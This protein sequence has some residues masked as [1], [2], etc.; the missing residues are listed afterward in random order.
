MH[1]VVS[2]TLGGLS[3]Q[4]YVR[5]FAFGAA[6]AAVIISMGARGP[7]PLPLGMI[8]LLVVNAVL[9]PYSRFVYERAVGFVVG[10]NV[11][12]VPAFISLFCKVMTMALCFAGAMFL[13]PVGLA[14]LYFNH[15]AP[16]PPRNS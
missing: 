12:I 1:S 13:A 14:Y 5:Q 10:D 16:D 4:Y 6:M 8:V 15:R 11:F 3:L 2:K 7:H 9:Y